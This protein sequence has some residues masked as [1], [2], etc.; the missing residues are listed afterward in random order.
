MHEKHISVTFLGPTLLCPFLCLRP[1]AHSFNMDTVWTNRL[2][3]GPI[4]LSDLH[5]SEV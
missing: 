4:S 2:N 5:C 3:F 1:K